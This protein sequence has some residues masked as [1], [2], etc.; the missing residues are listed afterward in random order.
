MQ[1]TVAK[2]GNFDIIKH[3]NIGG[4]GN[5]MSKIRI[6]KTWVCLFYGVGALGMILFAFWDLKISMALCNQ[7]NL[8]GKLIE[9]VGDWPM[10]LSLGLGAMYLFCEELKKE[11][12]N[13]GWLVLW[14]LGSLIGAALSSILP[15]Y[16]MTRVSRW[17][18]FLIPVFLLLLYLIV[19]KMPENKRKALHQLAKFAV[20]YFI[21]AQVIAYGIKAPWGRLRFRHM[22]EPLTQFIPWYLPQGLTGNHSFPSGHT[23]NSCSILL[24]LYLPGIR[25]ENA[26]PDLRL[27]LFVCAWVF[28]VAVGRIIAGAHFASDVTMGAMLG[29]GTFLFMNHRLEA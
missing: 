26:Q 18:L 22:S 1:S 6:S 15:I 19:Q 9:A 21:A 24:L 28:M 8:F 25:K 10:Y 17:H 16:R 29:I 12:K 13:P 5:G 27:W 2:D 7:E 4:I 11:K 3:D 14:G 23:F 20:I